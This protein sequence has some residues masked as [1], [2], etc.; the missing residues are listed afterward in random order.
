MHVACPCKS[1]LKPLMA[2]PLQLPLLSPPTDLTVHELL[3][4]WSKGTVA[5]VWH[6]EWELWP[7]C[8]HD[9]VLLLGQ[10]DNVCHCIA[11]PVPEEETA[12]QGMKATPLMTTSFIT[13]LKVKCSSEE[14]RLSIG[15][16]LQSSRVFQEYRRCNKVMT[17]NEGGGV[18]WLE[19]ILLYASV[20]S[21]PL[22][23]WSLMHEIL[24]SDCGWMQP[25]PIWM[26]GTVWEGRSISVPHVYFLYWKK[27]I[28]PRSMSPRMVPRIPMGHGLLLLLQT[29]FRDMRRNYLLYS[30]RRILQIVRNYE[31]S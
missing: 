29:T 2:H 12:N 7:F 10:S 18:W 11:T 31:E 13:D 16:C 30:K 22:K 6:P 5:G 21:S 4:H 26:A 23:K 27:L 20:F 9:R 19:G 3:A 14:L 8:E 15:P 17:A 28:H 25:E 24:N 1:H